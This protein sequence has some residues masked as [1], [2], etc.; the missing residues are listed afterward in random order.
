MEDTTRPEL[1]LVRR[2]IAPGLIAIPVALGLGW[3]IAGRDAGLSAGLGALV[4]LANFVANGAS[5]AFASRISLTAVHGVALGGVV[6]RL[7]V[8]VAILFALDPTAWFSPAAFGAAAVPGTLAL[9]AYEAR[10]VSRGL[11]GILQV[12]PVIGGRA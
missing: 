4:V 12:P 6:I 5:L 8:I 1:E 10:L 2:A 9:L 3:A 11:G 7:G